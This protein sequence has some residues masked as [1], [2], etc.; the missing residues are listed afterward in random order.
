MYTPGGITS[1]LQTLSLTQVLYKP[2]PDIRAIQG[3]T[4]D[5]NTSDVNTLYTDSLERGD[6]DHSPIRRQPS[7]S[8]SHLLRR[9]DCTVQPYNPP[10]VDLQTFPPFDQARANVFRYR[11]QQSVNLGSWFVHEQWMTPSLFT[12]AAA[13]QV[14]EVD[15]AHGWGSS[16]GARSVL[17]RHWDTFINETDFEYLSSIGINTVRLPIGYWNLG[18][19][20]VDGTPYSDVGDVY[21]NCWSRIVRA[22]NWA[23]N[24]DIGVLVDLHGAPGSQNGQQH[25]GISDGQTNLFDNPENIQRAMDVLTFLTQQLV[26]VSN[27]VGIQILNEPQNVDSLADFYTQA[28]TT[29]RNSTPAAKNFPLYLHD[30]FDL[31]RFS[32]F[33]AARTDFVVEDHHSYFVFTDQDMNESATDHTNDIEGGISQSLVS[34]SAAQHRNLVVD[35]WSCALTDQSLKNQPNGAQFDFCKAQMDVYANSS[36][37][38]SFWAYRKESCND[39]PGWCFSAA[40]GNT[41]P[42]T[43]FSYNTDKQVDPS[44]LAFLSSLFSTASSESP[45]AAQ[46]VPTPDAYTPYRSATKYAKRYHLR[47]RSASSQGGT[48]SLRRRG[49]GNSGPSVQSNGSPTSSSFDPTSTMT[50][51]QRASSKGYSDGYQ[52]AKIFASYGMSRLGFTGQYIRDSIAALGQNVISRDNEDTYTN[53]FMTGLQDGEALITKQVGQ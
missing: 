44:Q 12:C 45:S 7:S 23:N 42:S 32:Q 3:R 38:W 33:V 25:S 16:D 41:L 4:L 31:D 17:E 47:R 29:M 14:S 10:T 43:F 5:L 15:I 13:N 51:S 53:S 39:D 22:I 18:P 35:E 34:A 46:V 27:V 37:G 26:N 30:G 24:N 36:A 48:C 8:Y 9:A 21:Q 52:T 2:T 11:Q 28:I 6:V 19:D 40:V 49:N 50:P 20:F 1:L